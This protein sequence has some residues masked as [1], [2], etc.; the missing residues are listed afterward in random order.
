MGWA[1]RCSQAH[2]LEHLCLKH[3]NRFLSCSWKK[4]ENVS[5]WCFFPERKWG[6][7]SLWSHV[8]LFLWV[9]VQGC[10]TWPK[11]CCSGMGMIH[12]GER[13]ASSAG[14]STT[15]YGHIMMS[16]LPCLIKLPTSS[17]TSMFPAQGGCTLPAGTQP[18]QKFPSGTKDKRLY[19]TQMLFKA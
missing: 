12:S 4:N 17:G 19:L 6:K 11:R 1:G 9:I 15:G 16:Q 5:F 14:F 13:E 3:H 8:R 7:M 2:A 10:H 18:R